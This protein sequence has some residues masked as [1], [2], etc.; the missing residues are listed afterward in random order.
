[1]EHKQVYS[2]INSINI[3][4]IYSMKDYNWC[5]GRFGYEKKTEDM[6]YGDLTWGII[7]KVTVHIRKKK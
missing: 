4:S 2:F 7:Y 3:L 1:M 6:S 5:H